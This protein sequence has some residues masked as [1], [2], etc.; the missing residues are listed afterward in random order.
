MIGYR[1]G[2]GRSS[3][4]EGIL[5]VVQS[6]RK[7][8]GDIVK[9][10]VKLTGLLIANTGVATLMVVTIKIV[11]DAGLG[12]GP[13]DTS[14]HLSFGKETTFA[15]TLAGF[16][17]LLVWTAKQQIVAAPQWFV[18]EATGLYDEELAQC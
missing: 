16:T 1:A 3:R 15:N 18:G 4:Y 11:R 6:S 13:V 8:L 9:L 7:E 14:Q 12:I 5:G 2:R 17:A 10:L